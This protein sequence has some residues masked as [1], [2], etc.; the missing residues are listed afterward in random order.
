[1]ENQQQYP[2]SDDKQ[3]ELGLEANGGEDL[4]DIEIDDDDKPLFMD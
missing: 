1:M 3:K 2:Q 4:N